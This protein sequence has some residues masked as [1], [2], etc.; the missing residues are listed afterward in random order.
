MATG[1]KAQNE[2]ES[3]MLILRQLEGVF[4][5]STDPEQRRRVAREIKQIKNSISNLQS[6]LSVQQKYGLSSSVDEDE[7]EEIFKT[8][9]RIP[10]EKFL[11]GS[12]D[13]EMQALIS[14]VEFYEKNY[15]PVLS[16]YY[17]K[18]D[19]NHSMKRDTFYPRYMELKKIMK[20]YVYEVEVQIGEEYNSIA[21]YKDKSIVYKLRQQ[22][23]M[24]LDKYYKELKVF[25]EELLEDHSSGGSIVLNPLDFINMSEFEV[26]RK[27]DGYTVINGILEIC[28]FCDEIIQFLA[29]PN[30]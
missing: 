22:Y 21:V 25:L 4:R 6:I 28:S 5:T 27:L 13:S 17:M 29:I 3:K 2:L 10:V 18:L 9:N 23:L 30:L 15:L 1:S 16:E 19:Y 14:Y 7:G 26:D 11:K 20:E 8:L 24:L 12:R